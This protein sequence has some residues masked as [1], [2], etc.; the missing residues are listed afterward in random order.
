MN[1]HFDVFEERKLTKILLLIQTYSRSKSI[2]IKN[3]GRKN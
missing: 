3:V 2:W 1:D